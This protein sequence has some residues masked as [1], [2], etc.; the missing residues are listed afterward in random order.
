MKQKDSEE[1]DKQL[2]FNCGWSSNSDLPPPL[3][4]PHHP[5]HQ[6]VS[7]NTATRCGR[8]ILRGTAAA[9]GVRVVSED[10]CSAFCANTSRAALSVIIRS[11]SRTSECC[12]YL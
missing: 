6:E 4:H 1:I 2:M 12:R 3:H 11:A 8:L 7:C 5:D 9:L 10:F